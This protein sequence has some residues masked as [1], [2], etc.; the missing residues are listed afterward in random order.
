MMQNTMYIY[1]HLGLGDHISCHG[2]VR[3]FCEIEES[4]GLF[5]KPHNYEN[6]KYMFNDLSNLELIT[7][8]NDNDVN[9]FI[10]IN[11]LKNVLRIGYFV[12][13][14][15]SKCKWKNFEEDF[16]LM[17]GLPVEY[18]IEKFFINRNLDKELDIF[19]SLNLLKG[20]YIFIHDGNDSENF[21]SLKYIPQNTKFV[22]PISYG[23]FDW[24]YTIENSKEI[25]CIDSSFICLVDCLQTLDKPLYNH[26]YVKNYDERTKIYTNKNWT[27]YAS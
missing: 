1:H 18:K 2:I 27:F 3:H 12:G 16:Y 15:T 14:D 19:N 17:A 13:G 21:T 25:H 23:L 8:D 10:C 22:K 5:V 24:I 7:L 26:R 20:E 9:G 6:V 4:V 11:E